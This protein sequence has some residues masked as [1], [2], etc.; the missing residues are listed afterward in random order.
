LDYKSFVLKKETERLE[1]ERKALE[2]S[3]AR[4]DLYAEFFAILKNIDAVIIEQE[5]NK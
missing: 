2:E 1:L 5:N 4:K 3:K